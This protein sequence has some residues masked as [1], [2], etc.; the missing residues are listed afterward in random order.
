MI[1]GAL[2]IKK[3]V[4]ESLLADSPCVPPESGGIL[5]GNDKIV[6]CFLADAGKSPTEF[7]RYEPDTKKINNVISDWLN[8][9]IDFIGIFHTHPS[10]DE[11]LSQADLI[12]IKSIMT[13]IKEYTNT[14]YFPIVI[15]K[16]K[17]ICYC[18]VNVEDEISV[19]QTAI[20]II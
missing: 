15:P 2:K 3:S 11:K 17:I 8:C 7:N 19:F 9:G 1:K 13:N 16:E 18:T 5:G 6:T 10:G 12:Y 4:Y 14:L 20:E